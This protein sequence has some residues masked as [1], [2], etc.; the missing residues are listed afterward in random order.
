MQRTQPQS[1]RKDPDNPGSVASRDRPAPG[2]TPARSMERGPEASL[3]DE[4]RARTNRPHK[5]DVGRPGTNEE[6]FQG[7]KEKELR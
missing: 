5:G 3:G 2:Q 7:S 1:L 6:V 4:I